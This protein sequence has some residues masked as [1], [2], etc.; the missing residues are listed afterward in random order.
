MAC[1]LSRQTGQLVASWLHWG[2]RILGAP[3]VASH[4]NTHFSWWDLIWFL[5]HREAPL[6][7]TL[8]NDWSTDLESHL[9]WYP[10]RE[11]I[12]SWI[13]E[14]N[15]GR[16]TNTLATWFEQQTHWKRPW[17]WDRLKAKGEEGGR[18]WDGWMASLIQWTWTW[19]NSGR[20]WGTERH[21][22][23]Q[24]MRSQRVRHDLVTE[25]NRTIGLTS[26]IMCDFYPHHP[27]VARL[28]E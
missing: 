28:L 11:L 19:A 1:S 9:T 14:Q 27:E 20:W 25:N 3:P 23:L 15:S 21:G 10:A 26:H 5:A 13:V 7:G 18:G 16:M 6:S 24:S 12:L 8:W 22:V 2:S 17:C 4:R